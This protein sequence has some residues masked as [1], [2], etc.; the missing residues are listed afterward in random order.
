MTKRMVKDALL[1]ILK[2]KPLSKIT[3]SELCNEAGI[4]RATFYNHY[5]TPMVVMKELAMDYSQKLSEIYETVRRKSKDKRDPIIACLKYIYECRDEIKILL[6]DNT[7]NCMNGIALA[8][9]RANLTNRGLD[10]SDDEYLVAVI[11]SSA[12]FGLIQVW[13]TE[14][15]K[16]TPEQIMDIL[17]VLLSVKMLK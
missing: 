14:D 12:A 8:I 3:I 16:K 5:D 11:T 13:I 2:R 10:S 7:E 1:K 9:I 15:I 6:S 4:N 17:S